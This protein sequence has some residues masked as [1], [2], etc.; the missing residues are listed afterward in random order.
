MKQGPHE[1]PVACHL[2]SAEFREREAT[3]LAQ[4]RS[5]VEE[6]ADGYAFRLPGDGKSIALVAD[7]IAAEREC[8]PFI[9]FELAA[10]PNAGPVVV[11]MTGPAGAKEFLRDVLCKPDPSI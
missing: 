9:A 1:L 10:H 4:F 7:L 2:S 6:L 5:A 11:R 8:C 3:V